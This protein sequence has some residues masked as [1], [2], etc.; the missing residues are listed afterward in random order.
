[1]LVDLPPLPAGRSAEGRPLQVLQRGTGAGPRVL[2][3]GQV[4]GDEPAG[5]RI[6][7]R[8]VAGPRPR[9]GTLFLIRTAN[10][11]GARRGTRVNSRGVDL[12]RNFPGTW[13][14]GARGRY[15][16]GP[17]AA[18]EPETRWLMRVVRA[19]RPDVTVWIHQ[20][21]RL[22]HLTPGANPRLVRA[23]A[24]RTRLPARPL[25]PLR[26]TATSWQNGTWPGDD[27]FVVELDGDPTP[28]GAV[29]RRHL[30]AIRALLSAG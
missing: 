15:F 17:R 16:P 8:L 5:P 1:M 2:V 13:R 19:V 7:A 28:S 10:P 25:P 22:I 4:H 9:T 11:D 30:N 18:S 29:V 6:V 24:R 14:P 23:Y 21:Y 12:N 27:A 26:G 20:P 3:V